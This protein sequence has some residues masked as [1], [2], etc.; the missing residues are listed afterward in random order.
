[1]FHSSVSSKFLNLS[2]VMMSAARRTRVS[3]LSLTPHPDGIVSIFHP[4]HPTVEWPSYSRRQPAAPSAA[5]SVLT[6]TGPLV[7][8]ACWA[9]VGH[10]AALQAASRY[11]GQAQLAD[12]PGQGR[13][14]DVEPLG[15]EQLTQLLLTRDLSRADDLQNGRVALG[16]HGAGIY[17]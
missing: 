8:P 6:A 15:P 17:P 5:V 13:L 2:V 10:G 7:A 9:R 1:M 12:V 3:S 11:F 16:L 14:G 4:R